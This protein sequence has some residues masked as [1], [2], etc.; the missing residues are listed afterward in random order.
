MAKKYLDY[1]GLAY[2][3]S[4]LKN[5][6]DLKVDKVT[7]KGL[8]T[9]DYT[10]ADQTKLAGIESGAQVNV[11]EGVQ[12]NGSSLTPT[13]KIVNVPVMD[14]ASSSAA[15]KVGLV[16][17]PASGAQSKFLKGDG[18]W[19]YPA[20]TTYTGTSPIDITGSVISHANS[21]V[22]AA[23]KGDTTNQTP[24]FGSTFKVTSG[25]VDAKGH[26]TAFA[27]HTVTIPSAEASTSAHGLMSSA[28][29]TKLNG[30]ASGAEVN[31][32]AFSTIKVGSTNIDAD[33]KSDTLTI[34]AGDNVTITP[35]AT[36]DKVTIAATDTTYS[37][38][39]TS[40]HGL[41]STTDKAKLDGITA[42]AEPN[43]QANWNESDST[44]D[45]FIQ[46]KP[47][48]PVA[49]TA[50]PQMDGT[51]TA[52]TATTWAP[53]DHVHPTDTSR[54]AASHTHVQAD[55]TAGA[56]SWYGTCST[57]TS[58]M[59]KVVSCSSFAL[60]TG[61]VI[62]VQFTNGEYNGGAFKL[63]VNSTGAKDVYFNGAAASTSNKLG[64]E[65]NSA[66]TFMY[67]GSHWRFISTSTIA[68]SLSHIPGLVVLDDSLTSS[69]P[70]TAAS[71]IAVANAYAAAQA[72]IPATEKGVANGVAPLDG[73]GKIDSTYLPSYVDDVVEAY[74]ISGATE[75]SSGWL[76]LTASGAA[77]TPESGKIYVLMADSTSYATN[78]Q[79][80]WGGTTYVKLSDGGLTPI[81]TS[82]IDTIVA[83]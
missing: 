35:D 79:F 12:I 69:S 1:D 5:K 39:T 49:G 78:S 36:N 60:K 27:D 54:A 57:A 23:S 64:W 2:F 70:N 38:A 81:T 8:S 52:G 43:V 67:D 41:M 65:A 71:S 82:E 83:S 44:S 48:I 3:W 30:I 45:A 42:G 61:A 9:N 51:A 58:T 59:T 66:L 75:L 10:T 55:L 63:N 13:S 77:L 34:T 4:L 28:D 7:G 32:N 68:D 56:L 29:K 21:G 33:A 24:G 6:F 46:N 22:T 72:A 19:D 74:P 31:Q 26:M 53:I 50:N 80:R 47:S 76:S 17:A 37:D 40:M 20:G 16:P 25:T 11:I 15:G 14:G 73:S 62:T 18:S